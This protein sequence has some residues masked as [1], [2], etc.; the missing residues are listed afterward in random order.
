M[1]MPDL[2]I[3]VVTDIVC[4]WCLIGIVRLENALKKAGL[5]GRIIHHPFLLD[6]DLGPE[7][8]DVGEKLRK[9]GG[10]PVAI[11]ERIESEALKTGIKFELAKQ[12]PQRPT[13]AAHTLIRHAL[14]KGT[15]EA[16]AI[17]V[18]EAHFMTYDNIADPETLATLGE[19]HGFTREEALRL[20]T[21][22]QELAITRD[23]ALKASQSGISGVP[24]FVF[25]RRL[26]LSGCQPEEVFLQAIAQAT[27]A[28][29]EAQA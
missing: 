21:D 23:L 11:F 25:D 18:Y 8:I 27:G 16:L 13:S 4:P 29:V 10:D 15:Q 12:P 9:R 26:A 1:S 24:F 17:A 19:A 20:V 28:E 22:P 5:K 6:P 2:Q 3:D 14:E 7:G